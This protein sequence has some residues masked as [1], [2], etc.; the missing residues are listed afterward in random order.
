MLDAV[1]RQRNEAQDRAA[2]LEAQVIV[3]SAELELHKG[4]ASMKDQQDAKG[5]EAAEQVRGK[6]RGKK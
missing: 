4:L 3:L 2:N 1:I 5:E 6:K